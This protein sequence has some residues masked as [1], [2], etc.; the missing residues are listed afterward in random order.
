ML[1]GRGG[2]DVV[3]GA[4]AVGEEDAAV[5]I[6]DAEPRHGVGV[7][8]RAARQRQALEVAGLERLHE[9]VGEVARVLRRAPLP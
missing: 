2:P 3:T 7:R 8:E 9:A 5:G 4:L 1:D 6:G